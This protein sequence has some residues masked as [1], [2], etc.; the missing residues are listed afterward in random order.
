MKIGVIGP[1][2]PDDFAD[3]ISDS[4]TSMGI[5]NV[6]LGPTQITS[7]GRVG[8]GIKIA[9]KWQ[10]LDDR[11]QRHLSRRA[12]DAG[13]SMVLTVDSSTSPSV[14]KELRANG[15]SVALW[16][17]DH[18]ANY[19][20]G[21]MLLAPYSALFFK[22]PK[23]VERLRANLGLPVHYLAEACNP[24]WHRSTQVQGVEPV[25]VVAGN[26]YPSRIMLLERLIAAKIPLALYGGGFPRW[27]ASRAV[28]ALHTGRYLARQQKADVFRRAAAVLNNLHPAEID[29][30]NCRLFEAAGS[31]A[32]VLAESRPTISEL[33]EEN[34]LMVWKD[35]DELVE[36]SRAAVD[37]AG[38]LADV[39]DRAAL[40][41]HADHSY[42]KRLAVIIE[43]L[44]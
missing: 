9:R 7:N 3:N 42:S 39:G 33:F 23:I 24:N 6:R 43:K 41:A 13:C 1:Q 26:M 44:S 16:F 15:V 21:R 22:E 37:A 35:F 8:A 10:F 4:L 11:S 38:S 30:V 40:R 19:G 31:G 14:V 36:R 32:V 28:V 5:E 27:S 20:T 18:I 25:V 12:L 2:D 29:G 17:P 34:E